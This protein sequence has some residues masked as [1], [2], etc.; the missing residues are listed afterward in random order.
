MWSMPRGIVIA[1]LHDLLSAVRQTL[2]LTEAGQVDHPTEPP[3]NFI[4]WAGDVGGAALVP[5]GLY[6]CRIAFIADGNPEE[7]YT[8][9]AVSYLGAD[10][11]KVML[12]VIGQ[13]HFAA[14]RAWEAG[15]I[16]RGITSV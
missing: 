15:A 3:R 9:F 5:S 12:R 6:R 8:F 4:C 2:H 16:T 7:T 11:K 14:L 10:T 13:E 1:D